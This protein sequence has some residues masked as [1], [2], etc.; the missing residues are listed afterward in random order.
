MPSRIRPDRVN[1]KDL[2]EFQLVYACEDCVHFKAE[3]KTCL[4]GLK[5]EPHLK[6]NQ[7]KQARLSG[8][9]LFCRFIETD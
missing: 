3:S 8:E 6:L 7:I 9:M 4:I 1:F 2:K 5:S